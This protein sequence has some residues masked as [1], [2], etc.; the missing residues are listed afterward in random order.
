MVSWSSSLRRS[1]ESIPTD[2]PADYQE[3]SDFHVSECKYQEVSCIVWQGRTTC[4]WSFTRFI[5]A[6]RYWENALKASEAAWQMS[7]VNIFKWH[8]HKS[9][10]IVSMFC[11][12]INFFFFKVISSSLLTADWIALVTALLLVKKGQIRRISAHT[13]TYTHKSS[14]LYIHLNICL[15]LP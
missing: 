1:L 10:K 12:D 14:P 6:F 15:C 7:K 3:P 4:S 5:L 9:N 13:H 2:K 11:C 8:P